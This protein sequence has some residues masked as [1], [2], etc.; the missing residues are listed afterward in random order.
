MDAGGTDVWAPVIAAIGASLI[1]GVATFG[2][3]IWQLR[4]S[5]REQ[6][7]TERRRAYS[8]L[9]AVS[10]L[11]IHSAWM[12]RLM[13]NFRSGAS[14]ALDIAFRLRHPIDPLE[15]DERL[16]K[17]LVPLYRAWSDVWTVG[18]TESI[19]LA[20]QVVDLAG[21]VIGL[22]TERDEN[23]G[24]LTRAVL[25]EKWTEEKYNV[26]LEA[27]ESLS[28]ARRDLARLARDELG[29]EPVDLTS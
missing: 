26:W 29:I 23:R 17:D 22:A 8:A 16:R 14:E 20:N 12:L 3:A 15:V 2:V 21:H 13:I 19:P 10:G 27:T 1:T 4:R 7:Q 9:L 28:K 5:R 11:I 25:G 18:S 24:P 6:L